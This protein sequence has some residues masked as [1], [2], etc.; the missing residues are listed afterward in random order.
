MSIERVTVDPSQVGDERSKLRTLSMEA[1]RE[2]EQLEV[3]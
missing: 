3:G 1:F 2:S